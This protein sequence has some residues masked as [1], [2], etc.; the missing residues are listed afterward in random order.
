M[1][2]IWLFLTRNVRFHAPKQDFMMYSFAH[3]PYSVKISVVRIHIIYNI[4]S[5]LKKTITHLIIHLHPIKL[6]YTLQHNLKKLQYIKFYI[7][8]NK[9]VNTTLHTIVKLS[10]YWCSEKVYNTLLKKWLIALYIMICKFDIPFAVHM[11]LKWTSHGFDIPF[12][13]Y[14]VLRF[15]FIFNLECFEKIYYD[16]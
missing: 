11:V 6:H 10:A 9:T 1:C 13:V 4:K 2:K 3:Y 5:I 12:A 15:M 16:I 8:N 7:G 14:M